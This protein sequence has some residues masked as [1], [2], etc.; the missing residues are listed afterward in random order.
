MR[1]W[2]T[3]REFK[4]FPEGTEVVSLVREG[5]DGLARVDVPVAEGGLDMTKEKGVL[6]WWRWVV[7]KRPPTQRELNERLEQLF[8]SLKDSQAAHRDALL[9]LTGLYLTR[10]RILRQETGA[11]THVKTGD[12]YEVKQDAI[13]PSTMEA[14]MG[15]LMAVIQ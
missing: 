10:K 2:S 13:D 8:L 3:H 1:Q 15:E 6:G 12:R 11:F 5:E 4:R 9:W 14:A 7:K